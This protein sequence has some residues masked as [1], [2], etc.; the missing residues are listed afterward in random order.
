[1]CVLRT[2]QF[3]FKLILKKMFT[4][5]TLLNNDKLTNV[6]YFRF[7]TILCDSNISMFTYL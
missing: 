3:L 7:K 6:F 2:F 5:F 1:M 4:G